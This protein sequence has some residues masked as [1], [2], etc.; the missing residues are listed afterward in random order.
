[1]T[2]IKNQICLLKGQFISI[3]RR[4]LLE[5]FITYRPHQYAR[6]VT[7]ALHQV[8][9]VTLMPFV[10]KA[11]IV[12]LRLLASP[13]IKRLIHYDESHRVTHIQKFR[14]RRIMRR[15]DGIHAHCL[16]FHQFTVKGIFIEGCSQ[17]AEVMMFTDTIDLHWYR[18]E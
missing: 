3:C 6:M 10:E 12:V 18:I 16:Q 7:V 8:R 1:M 13:H 17:T 9:K 11:C 15:P 5:H 14:S 4:P 2:R